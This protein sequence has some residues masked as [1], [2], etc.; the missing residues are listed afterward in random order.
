MLSIV[1]IDMDNAVGVSEAWRQVWQELAVSHWN[2]RSASASQDDGSNAVA[3]VEVCYR[4]RSRY[5]R[6]LCAS[7]SHI[8]GDMELV[9]NERGRLENMTVSSSGGYTADVIPQGAV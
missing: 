9:L 8:M 3:E 4:G 6:R 1:C 2:T 5:V 7:R